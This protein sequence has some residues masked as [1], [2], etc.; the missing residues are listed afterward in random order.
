MS[1]RVAFALAA[2]FISRFAVAAWFDPRRDGDIAW[3][4]WLG[5]H[6]LQSG[7]LP[8][9][10]GPEAFAA[11]GAAWIPQ[12]W[13]LSV[14]IALTLG[15][16]AFIG[17]VALTTIAAVAVLFFTAIAAKRLGA[18]TATA[19]LAVVCVAFSMLESYGIRAQVFGW[20]LLAAMMY[21]LRCVP[22]RGKWWIVAI[23]AL[24][25]NVHASALLSPVLLALWAAGTAI[26]E[27][28]FNAK[29]REYALLAAASAGAV[30]L[31][32]LGYKLPL[33]TL[34]LL[35]SPIR[36]AI[37]EWQ[38]S[39]LSEISFTAGAL[40]L[41]VAACIRGFAPSRRWA[42]MFVF[43]AVT[44]LALTAVRNVPVCA[45]V[46]SPAVAAR[47]AAWLPERARVN[48]LFTERP[49]IALLFS[50]CFLAAILSGAALAGSPQFR[51]GNLPRTAIERLASMPGTHRLYCEDFAWCSLALAHPNLQEFI[52][53]R[54]DPFPLSVWNDYIT[55]FHA[56]TNW[57]RVVD[58]RGIDAIVV[59][60]KRTL[61][62]AL[63]SWQGWS[64]VYADDQYRLFVRGDTR[65]TAYKQ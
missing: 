11:R 4:Q 63:A 54:C 19:A 9:A 45:I 40:V 50:G 35:H 42:E 34:E 25:S 60:K 57:R 8:A 27:R 1:L 12:E 7:R 47:L 10:L 22:G 26:Q 15:K 55:V 23:V 5:L 20:A 30:F 28:S 37:N 14:L 3:Q 2:V 48:T 33:Y 65:S 41:I 13:A 61:A 56:K 21:T 18:S 46:I 58:R 62:H 44:W 52:D 32:P 43:A 39:S 36:T 24:W 59:D 49:V 16:P 53:G 38:P 29:V 17:L 6:I 31:T 64:L 51:Q